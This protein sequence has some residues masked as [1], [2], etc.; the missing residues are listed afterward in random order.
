MIERIKQIDVVDWKG[1]FVALT[2]YQAPEGSLLD[3]DHVEWAKGSLRRSRLLTN[4]AGTLVGTPL[5]IIPYQLADGS[6]QL[7]C[8]TSDNVYSYLSSLTGWTL[9]G[10]YAGSSTRRV[11]YDTFAGNLI[12]TDE[13]N[14]VKKYDGTTLAD[15]GGLTATLA[16]AVLSFWSFFFL[17]H[18]TEAAIENP[19]R[20]R[21]SN[22]GDAENWSTGMASFVDLLDSWGEVQVGAVLGNKA[23]VFKDY[24]AYAGLYV[25]LPRVFDWYPLPGVSGIAAPNTLARANQFLIYLGEDDVYAFD[26]SS[27]QSI[28]TP[29]REWI[30]GPRRRT[31]TSV[32][33]R[34]LGAYFPFLQEY[35]LAVPFDGG[36]AP[37]MLLRFHLPTQTWWPRTNLSTY[38][39]F[40]S[41][42]G[43]DL[44]TWNDLTGTWNDFG[45]SETWDELG[46]LSQTIKI[47]LIGTLSGASGQLQQIEEE[48]VS[49]DTSF[50]VT[51][52]YL[53]HV[54][55]RML[56][57]KIEARGAGGQL[58]ASY[59][60][61]EGA[62]WTSLGAS[63]LVGS[64]WQWLKWP[65]NVTADVVRFKVELSSHEI[66]IRKRVLIGIERRR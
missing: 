6:Y 9:R 40:G 36:T 12:F 25:G 48:N 63:T 22:I 3:A 19:H 44:L 21:W 31:T 4:F 57:F 60:T 20:V 30:A 29:I 33:T 58:T 45:V 46:G 17:L 41:W 24:G 50:F 7:V 35:W 64:E 14:N 11:S 51:R 62:T 52:D 65:L 5:A 53:F 1:L 47:P 16:R 38:R 28:G 59:S 8:V 61:D 2:G 13:V 32:I 18:T 23:F 54:L 10:V 42:Y 56:E 26:G 37:Y 49:S 55:T 39:A 27:A 15:L 43:A 66:S 34:S